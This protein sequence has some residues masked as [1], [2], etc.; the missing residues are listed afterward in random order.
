MRP[1]R[2]PAFL[3]VILA[4]SVLLVIPATASGSDVAEGDV[5][6]V[7]YDYHLR[8]DAG[9][10]ETFTIEVVNYLS[11]LEN[12]I[13]N[14]R[15]VS[16]G[17]ASVP[18]VEISV[19][20]DNKN[21]VLDGQEHRSVTVTVSVNKYATAD[22]YDLEVILNVTT[23]YGGTAVTT[24]PVHVELVVQSPLSSG[25]TYNKIMGIFKNPF[26]EPFN[27]PLAS[28]VIT[29][30]LW[31]VIGSLAMI[32]LV[33]ILL[34]I[35]TQNGKEDGKKVK[36]GLRNILFLAVLLFAFDSGLRVYGAAE[37]IIG[38]VEVW[39]NVF[40]V[41]LGAV[42]VWKVYLI[43]I[44]HTVTRISENRRIDRREM[45]LEPLLRLFGKLVIWVMAVAIIM[46]VWGFNLTAIITS[47]GIISLGI[48]LGAQNILNQFFSGMV[49]LLTRPF[50]SGDLVKIGTNS[51]IYKVSNVNI[52]NTV[53]ENWDNEETVIMPNNAVSSSTIVNL[54]GDGLIYKIKVFMNIAYEDDIDLA[55]K[56]MEKVAT[57]HPSIITDGSVDLPSTRVTAF[58][59]SSI[60]IRITGYVYDFND[61][62]RIGGELREAMFKAFKENGISVPFPQ[63][64]IHIKVDQRNDGQRD[65]DD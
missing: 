36:R 47:A 12:D 6:L 41:A 9:S 53:F 22:T 11:Y 61:N 50:R 10:S 63:R 62:G 44:Q 37:D 40:Y 7:A 18:N 54:T 5:G 15:M 20:D 51:A 49:L 42:I 2:V 13:E 57:E 34:R 1:A 8:I 19:A 35:F 29:F 21:F 39:F 25:D 14:S 58:L 3:L 48:T 59:D 52:M 27:S 60:E 65:E 56:L 43:F 31:A 16:I 33:P 30:V 64:D 38:P 24:A 4:I 32:I 26:P 55:K 28:S 46:S 45:D 17:F 23:L